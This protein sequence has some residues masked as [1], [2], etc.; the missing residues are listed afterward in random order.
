MTL[1]RSLAA[2]ALAATALLAGCA[3]P[4]QSGSSYNPNEVRRPMSVQMATVQAVRE[5]RIDRSQQGPGPA[6]DGATGARPDVP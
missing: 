3:A 1:S 6:Q 5:V 2:V 4:R